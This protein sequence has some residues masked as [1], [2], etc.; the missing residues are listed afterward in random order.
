M[1]EVCAE[2]GT[3]LARS[4]SKKGQRGGLTLIALRC[5]HGMRNRQAERKGKG[6][7]PGEVYL[8]EEP[9]PWIVYSWE[10]GHSCCFGRAA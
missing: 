10:G 4:T 8:D 7:A 9:T 2:H 3:R 1:K 6:K 5:V